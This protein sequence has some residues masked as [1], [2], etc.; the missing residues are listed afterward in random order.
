MKG[1]MAVRLAA[2]LALGY[3]VW[4]LATGPLQ[5][6]GSSAA[7]SLRVAFAQPVA[8]LVGLVAIA[9]GVGLWG[10]RAWAWWLGLAGALVQLWRLAWPLVLGPGAPRMPGT[11]TLVL[12]GVMVV[13]VVLLMWPRAR[14]ACGR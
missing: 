3:G 8:W 6:A 9:V 2:L 12:I 14:A 7:F 11:V 4:V 13:L 1:P 10:R 5:V